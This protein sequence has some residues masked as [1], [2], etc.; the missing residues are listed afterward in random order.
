MKL[1][2]MARRKMMIPGTDNARDNLSMGPL[3]NF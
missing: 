3:Y 2:I 1:G